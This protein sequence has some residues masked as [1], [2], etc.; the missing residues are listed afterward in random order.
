MIRPHNGQEGQTMRNHKL[1]YFDIQLFADGGGSGSAAG[2]TGQ[3][4]AAAA[5]A[6][7]QTGDKGAQSS[8]VRF[9]GQ[10][11][12]PAAGEAQVAEDDRSARFNAMIK[13]EFKDLYD[14]RVSDTIKRRLKG[15]EEIVNKF[16]R[17]SGTF[18]LLGGKYGLD[19]NAPDF[20]DKLTQEIEKDESYFEDEALRKGMSVEDVKE[21]RRIK[22]ENADLTKKL[23]DM[24][25]QRQA[26]DTI[27]SWNRQAEALKETYPGFDLRTELQNEQFRNLLNS[28]ISIKTA[29]EVIH[30]DEI[31][32]AAM[33]Y[34]A[35]QASSKVANAVRAG[36]S[37]PAE[38]AMGRG[39][40]ALTKIDVSKLTRA[41]V[42]EYNRRAARGERIEF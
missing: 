19:P 18:D 36:Q 12:A 5:P 24:S 3:A 40:A 31:F 38:G 20:V 41:E 7:P 32:P 4:P 6:Q 15:T 30:K 29:F 8:E 34:A 39:A 17:L 13:G 10:N 42:E 16:N 35:K 28:N 1:P 23:E 2:A 14:A 33:Q 25:T 11:A 37:R 21:V 22:R 27:A 26:E 9:G